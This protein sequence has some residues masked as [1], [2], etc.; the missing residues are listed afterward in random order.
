MAGMTVTSKARPKGT[1]V[2]LNAAPGIAKRRA[3]T[4]AAIQGGLL[5]ATEAGVVGWARDPSGS[6]QPVRVVLTVDDLPIATALADRYDLPAVI[7]RY[8]SEAVGFFASLPSRSGLRAPFDIVARTM[9]GQV[10]GASMKVVDLG[11]AAPSQASAT[12]DGMIDYLRSG[13][14]LGWAW[15]PE[16]PQVELSVDLL[17]GPHLVARTT[18]HLTRD[19]L[20]AAG[21]R[22]GSCAFCF[23]LPASLLDMRVHVLRVVLT[24]TNIELPGGPIA[25]GPSTVSPL[26]Q[27]LV[28]LRGEVRRLTTLVE[29]V[30]RPDGTFQSALVQTLLARVNAYAEIHN[31]MILKRLGSVPD[32]GSTQAA[33]SKGV[34]ALRRRI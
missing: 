33:N 19:D 7:E 34:A 4:A 25:F 28:G 12:Y 29:G 10:L 11:E 17:D 3:A 32:T 20:K 27:E 13:R 14:L 5:Q 30:A 1:R 15:N 26:V 2:R 23:D 16:D 9:D 18:A 21:K 31:E 6:A 22:D 8:G 24:D